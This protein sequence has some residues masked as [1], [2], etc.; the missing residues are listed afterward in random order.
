M[1][2]TPDARGPAAARGPFHRPIRVHDVPQAGLD[3]T[4]QATPEECRAIAADAGLPDVASLKAECHVARRASGRFDVTG[5][6]ESTL[7]Q[8]CVV[9]LEP[10]ESTVRQEIAISFAL[11]PRDG[12]LERGRLTVDID[13]VEGAD[14]PDPI[15]DNTI[16][17]GAVA[18]E[19]LT[20]ALDLYPK[21]PGVHFTDV[22]I[23]EKLEPEPSTFA[24][25]ERLKDKS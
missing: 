24:A 4:L 7:T 3:R 22:L 18:L 5:A 25:L 10:F 9:S 23:G 2:R 8:N 15:V 19:F 16:D 14:E 17:L 21:K 11:P 13:V 1:A 20:L 6:V 12:A